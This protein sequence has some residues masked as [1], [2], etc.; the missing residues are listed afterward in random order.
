MLLR[1]S[2]CSKSFRAI[3]TSK[4]S[5]L[6]WKEALE[7]DGLKPF[8]A[9]DWSEIQWASFIWDKECQVRLPLTFVALLECGDVVRD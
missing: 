4:A 7:R 6:I 1:I 3:L 2:R 9:D 5:Q 8:L